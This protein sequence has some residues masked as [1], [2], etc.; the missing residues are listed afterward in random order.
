M[1]DCIITPGNR[2][3]LHGVLIDP[4]PSYLIRVD[5]SLFAGAEY[6]MSGK[7]RSMSL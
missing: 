4:E 1:P 5:F 3:P 2:M 7:S 6:R